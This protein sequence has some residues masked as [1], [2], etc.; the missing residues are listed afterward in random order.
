MNPK[1]LFAPVS[2]RVPRYC[3][4]EDKYWFVIEA[5]LEDGRTWELSRCYE[6]FYDFQIAL[7]T[8]FPVEA[9]TS[10]IRSERTIPYMPGPVNYVT[11]AITDGRRHSLDVYLNHLLVLPP[12]IAHCILVKQFFGPREADHEIHRDAVDEDERLSAGSRLSLA[13]D[14]PTWRPRGSRTNPTGVGARDGDDSDFWRDI[15]A[16]SALDVSWAEKSFNPWADETLMALRA[17]SSQQRPI[18]ESDN[19]GDNLDDNGNRKLPFILKWSSKLHTPKTPQQ[20]TL[21]R[22]WHAVRFWR[23]V[24]FGSRYLAG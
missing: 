22:C 18:N 15:F 21:N 24:F 5:K 14:D 4:A 11:D 3:F 16:N 12:H 6:D 8:E 9:G 17:N 2:A 10:S 20:P 7:L 19:I 23:G 13:D 1:K